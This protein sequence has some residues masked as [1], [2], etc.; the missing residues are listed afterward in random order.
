MQKKLCFLQIPSSY[1]KFL[2]SRIEAFDR[3]NPAV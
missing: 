2:E 1:E 3:G